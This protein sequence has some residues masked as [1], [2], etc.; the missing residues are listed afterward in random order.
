MKNMLH[1]GL[2]LVAVLSLSNCSNSEKAA[3]EIDSL[4]A[5][6]AMGVTQDSITDTTKALPIDTEATQTQ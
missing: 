2:A 1:F 4:S 3:A 6:S 5:D